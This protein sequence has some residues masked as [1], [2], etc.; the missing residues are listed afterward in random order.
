MRI[1]FLKE[2]YFSNINLYSSG[3]L[4]SLEYIFY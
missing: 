3:F 4:K 1:F 2:L